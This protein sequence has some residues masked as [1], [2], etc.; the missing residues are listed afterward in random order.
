MRKILSTLTLIC[1]MAT[2][3]NAQN[4]AAGTASE[5]Q[6]RVEQWRGKTLMVFTPHPDDDVFGCGGIMA[7]LARNDNKIIVVIYTNDNK[8][9]FDSDWDPKDLEKLVEYLKGRGTKKDGKYGEAF[10]R[11]TEFNSQ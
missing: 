4:S 1:A 10:R 5:T 8:G 9:S 3:I 2:A 11:A 6:D 7:M